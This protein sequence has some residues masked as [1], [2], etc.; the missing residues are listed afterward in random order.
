[1]T[2]APQLNEDAARA[3]LDDPD[4]RAT[5]LHGLLLV[6]FGEQLYGSEE[7]DPMDSLEIFAGLE[8]RFN[9]SLTEEVENK[10]QALLLAMSTD[11]FY[12]DPNVFI[13]VA[14]SLLDGDL[15]DLPTGG[16]SGLSQME[17][18]WAIYEVAVNRDD[19]V[20]DFSP[21]VQEMI[22]RLVVDEAQEDN[23]PDIPIDIHEMLFLRELRDNV[24][25]QMTALWGDSVSFEQ[26]IPD[27]AEIL[28]P[29]I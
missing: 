7:L 5:A 13:A 11:G 27:P 20:P 17:I 28:Q 14:E 9:V 23:D 8:E 22:D 21:A 15:G 24:L 3:L 2:A 4:A 12:E 1:M 18:L 10:I 29:V 25:A 16:S 26:E 6:A 19:N